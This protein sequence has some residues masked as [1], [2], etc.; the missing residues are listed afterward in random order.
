MKLTPEERKKQ[1]YYRDARYT[2]QYD[3]IWQTVG[4]CVF[5]DMRDKYIFYEEH[6]IVMTVSL[7]AYID[8]HFM[9]VPRRHIKSPKELTQLEWDTIRKFSYIAKKLIRKV[10]G[11]KG[12]QLVQKEG[13]EA[14]S[15]VDQHLH[16]HCVPFD[17]PDLCEWN[18]RKLSFTPIENAEKYREVKKDIVSLDIK[19]ESKYKRPS[20]MRIVCD[21][22]MINE[23]NQILFQERKKNLKLTPDYLTLPG[24]GVENFD[25]S[26]ENEL[27]REVFEETGVKINIDQTSLLDSRF[28]KTTITRRDVHLNVSFPVPNPFLWITYKVTISSKAKLT[29]GDD[30][31]KLIWIDYDKAVTHERVS[32]GIRDVLKK[33]FL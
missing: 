32:S 3:N 16:F 8:G 14:Q 18:Y 33:I 19:Y 22:I 17:A 27:A 6:G 23:K 21:A 10:H 31:E 13:I 2:K 1:E 26:L 15:T 9:I 28:G 11:I 12:M 29:P 25:T 20:G 5:C 7:Y 30:C 4:K 24:G